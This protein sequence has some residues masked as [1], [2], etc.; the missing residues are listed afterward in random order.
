MPN[1]FS[2]FKKIE[3]HIINLIFAEVFIQIINSALLLILLIYMQKSGYSDFQS[4]DFI[5]YRFLGTLL[6]ALPLGF[7]LKGRPIKPLFLTG[8]LAIPILTLIMIYAIEYKADWL[9][10]TSQTLWGISFLCFQITA[11]PYIIRTAKKE[12]HT[13]AITLSFATYSFGGIVSGFLIYGLSALNPVFFDEKTILI[14]FSLLGFV[15]FYFV[16]KIKTDEK[17]QLDMQEK[18]TLKVFDY[19]WMLIFKALFPVLIIATGAGLSIPFVGSFF[20]NIHHLPASDF[21]FYGSVAAVLVALGAMIV[22]L[23][24]RT[25]GYQIAVP[26][27][28]SMAVFT[29]II[30][31]A[32]E[33][34]SSFSLAASVA[35][36]CYLIRQPLMNIASP[37]TSEVVMNYVG[38]KNRE[39]AS[40]LTSA[41]WSGSWF[42]SSRIF[43]E[44]RE[45][46]FAYVNVFLIT[47]ML[48]SIGILC[49]YLLIMDYNK[50]I[51]LG[52]ISD[53]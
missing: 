9:L 50:R 26:L 52:L 13:E 10:Y 11:L 53:N 45:T 6:F 17:G 5:S 32:T 14:V 46:G 39:M 23:I 47:A 51:K 31:A 27:T 42:I 3:K 7:L 2:Q 37:M 12:T 24:K 8:S 30:L 21:A 19:D 49:Y 44:L 15:S 34:F 18:K 41:I 35:I 40:A 43:K 20:F 1:F 22:P 29:L 25:L 48:Y 16:T 28:Q 33:W 36:A 38:D 4:A